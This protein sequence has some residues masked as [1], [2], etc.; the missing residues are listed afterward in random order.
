[1][2]EA[3]FARV[4]NSSAM[5]SLLF[6]RFPRH[7]LNYCADGEPEKPVRY[8]L[9]GSPLCKT[10]TFSSGI[11]SPRTPPDSSDSS[12]RVLAINRGASALKNKTGR[13]VAG[14]NKD[15]RAKSFYEAPSFKRKPRVRGTERETICDSG[16]RPT[17]TT[18]PGDRRRYPIS[19]IAST[20]AIFQK[21][22]SV[23]QARFREQAPTV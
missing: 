12:C 4:Q 3:H 9:H 10:P 18:S 6:R 21:T 19:D 14:R 17:F 13:N 7:S 23:G 22:L 1:M 20:G 11:R 15:W 8:R 16:G 5:A 2:G